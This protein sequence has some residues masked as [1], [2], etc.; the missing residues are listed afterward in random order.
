MP[1][2]IV[3]ASSL[4]SFSL[5]EVDLSLFSV[6]SSSFKVD[7]SSI[8]RPFPISNLVP[9]KSDFMKMSPFRISDHLD[10][11]K[12]NNTW[13]KKRLLKLS[14]ILDRQGRSRRDA[15]SRIASGD[16]SFTSFSKS[17]IC[18]APFRGGHLHPGRGGV[19]NYVC[20]F[21]QKAKAPPLCNSHDH[22]YTP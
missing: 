11:K 17:S 8:E 21:H 12:S 18:A 5:S 16:V 14:T 2:P 15:T 13:L 1:K 20:I 6:S 7:L 3:N 19:I 4:A 9:R 22:L 10:I